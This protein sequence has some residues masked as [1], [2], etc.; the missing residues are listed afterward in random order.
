MVVIG[1]SLLSTYDNRFDLGSGDDTRGSETVGC[2]IPVKY[3]GR[4][5]IYVSCAR[6]DTVIF[7]RVPSAWR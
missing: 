2:C 7:W 3:T 5:L 4:N 1:Q 6:I